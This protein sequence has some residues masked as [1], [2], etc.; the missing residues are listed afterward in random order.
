M[1]TL[2]FI[3]LSFNFANYINSQQIT[4]LDL[5]KGHTIT[6][7]TSDVRLP[8]KYLFNNKNV[9]IKYNPISI[10]FGGALYIYQRAISPQISAGCAYEISCS[11]FSKQC[12]SHY[13][14]IKGIALS[15]DRLTRCNKIASADFHPLLIN[16]QNKV[17]DNPEMY[18]LRK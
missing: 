15:T 6:T 4:D 10:F 9:F 17:I 11:N 1:K 8:A 5:I 16:N 7:S 18:K 3:Y 13:G 12:I 2:L 14:F